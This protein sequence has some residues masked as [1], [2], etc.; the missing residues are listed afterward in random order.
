M[1]V[2]TTQQVSLHSLLTFILRDKNVIHQGRSVLKE[3]VPS[4]F[5][6]ASSLRPRAVLNTSRPVNKT[7]ISLFFFS[8]KG[9]Q[10]NQSHPSAPTRYHQCK[11]LLYFQGYCPRSWFPAS[12]VRNKCGNKYSGGR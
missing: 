8:L 9:T 6:A 12:F 11:R 3:P 10:N 2:R 4:V 1:A 5:S 7:Y